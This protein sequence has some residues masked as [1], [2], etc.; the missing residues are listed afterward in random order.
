MSPRKVT[1]LIRLPGVVSIAAVIVVAVAPLSSGETRD[2]GSETDFCAAVNAL[3][4]GD[5]LRLSPGDYAAGCTVRNGG[6]RDAPIIIRASDP[7]NRPRLV[8]TAKTN[9]V[10][11]IAAN[12]VV[13]RGLHFGPTQT[14]VD[15][16]RVRS[17]D[18]ITVDD[19][20]FVE[21]GGV[22]IVANASTQ[23]LTLSNNDIRRSKTTAVYLGCHD[24]VGC[25]VTD[26]VIEGNHIEAVTAPFGQIGYGIQV[27]L[28]STA[29]VRD[30]VIVDTKGPGIMVYGSRDPG[31]TST[32]ERNFVASSRTSSGI[33]VGGGPAVVANNI[34][35]RTAQSGIALENYDGRGL[36][37]HI[38]V[39]N[40]TVYGG[41]GGGITVPATPALDAKLLYNASHSLTGPALPSPRAGIIALGNVDCRWLP[42]FVD[43]LAMDFAPMEGSALTGRALQ[44]PDVPRDDFFGTLRPPLAS[45]GAVQN[46]G[47]GRAVQGKKPRVN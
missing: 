47:S 20:V 40:N 43:P 45:A 35:V 6:T 10:L 46:G 11:N 1:W 5:E 41:A 32:V 9:N 44:G 8:F 37:R 38:V 33:V 15:G 12:S 4:P 19:C 42:C 2:I 21:I 31:L 27:K 25:R 23:R 36:L 24:G 7:T 29:L 16:V 30:N 14:D 3:A 22:A 17:G 28:N 34:V 39:S 26:A 13:L 18:D